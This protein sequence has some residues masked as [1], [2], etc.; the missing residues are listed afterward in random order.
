VRLIGRI[1]KLKYLK[2]KTLFMQNAKLANKHRFVQSGA[3]LFQ[4]M[5]TSG[6]SLGATDFLISGG[7]RK[8]DP[9]F[10]KRTKEEGKTGRELAAARLSNKIKFGKE[11]FMIGAGFPLI[12]PIFGGAVRTLACIKWWNKKFKGPYIFTFNC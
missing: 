3:N 9:L 6:L 4:R 7:E 10:F 11:G 12:G 2:G 5:G 1:G 8:L